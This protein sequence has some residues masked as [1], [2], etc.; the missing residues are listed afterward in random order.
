MNNK[1]NMADDNNFESIVINSDIP[2]LV[3][4]G[5]SWCSPC[6]RQQ[7]ILDKMFESGKH[8]NIKLVIVDTDISPQITKA[9]GIRSIPTLVFYQNKK[10]MFQ[11][12]GISS[13]KDLD[14]KISTILSLQE[15]Q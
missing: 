5:T 7:A 3:K 10:V 11:A 14:E 12:S 4:F 8:N 6:S 13:E 2:V 15:R 9:L 1:L